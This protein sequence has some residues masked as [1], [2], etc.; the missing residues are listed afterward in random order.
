MR[1]RASILRFGVLLLAVVGLVNLLGQ[2]L[3]FR[4][5]MTEDDRY[6]LSDATLRILDDLPEAVTVTAYFTEELPP[7][8]ERVKRAFHDLLVEYDRRSEGRVVFEF[9]DPAVDDAVE[10]EALGQ[11]IRP[12]LVNVRQKDKAEQLRAY[13]GA[14]V[15]M[16]DR[17]T[18]IPVVQGEEGLEWTL[19]S[20]IKE[21]SVADKPTLG[22]VQ[23]HG[24]P[25]MNELPQALQGLNV[26]YNV[27]Q[28]SFFDTLPVHERYDLL[29]M[30]APTDSV[31]PAHLHWM[32]EF[33]SRGN[34]IVLCLE[35]VA[36]Q[37]GSSPFLQARRTGLEDWLARKGLAVGNG[38]VADAS[39]GTVNIMQQRGHFSMQTPIPFPYFPLITSFP[40]HP[41]TTGADAVVMQFSA[42]LGFHGDTTKVRYTPLLRTSARSAVVPLP[43]SI[44][45][46]RQWTDAELMGPSSTI[47]AA[48]EGTLGGGEPARLV[49]F[50]NGRFAVNGTGQGMV[51]LN[52]DNV[53]LLVNAV[54]WVADRT[55]LIELRTKG[56]DYR[57]IRELEDDQRTLIKWS[58]LL[59]PILL[60][61]VYG[62]LR[63][64][65]RKA[66]RARR[67]APG[68]VQ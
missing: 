46:Q 13:M 56:T 50:T 32:D 65:W 60:V 38:T 44:D 2:K 25:S 15:K 58:Q 17:R 64:R 57:P 24:E 31:P 14:V 9:K 6:T 5:D 62:L 41:I 21:A 26:Q 51:Q 16:A 3:G 52:P 39:C 66:Q 22:F 19:S 34:G 11:Q 55:G 68:H 28:Y 12:V 10:Q 67:S 20:A 61:I 7:D 1:S 49:V 59:L 4:W 53:D 63:W 43:H 18:V 40:E 36:S 45:L 27:Q 33:L 47:G 30:V 54:D 37:L 29:L 8:L 48:L 35:P 23:G 42:P